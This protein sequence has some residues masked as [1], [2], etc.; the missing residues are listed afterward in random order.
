MANEPAPREAFSVGHKLEGEEEWLLL[1]L[2]LV[3][4]M[5][6]GGVLQLLMKHAG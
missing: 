1:L 4:V 2:L 5:A 6:V 3:V